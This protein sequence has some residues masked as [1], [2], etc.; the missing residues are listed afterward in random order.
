MIFILNTLDSLN[1]NRNQGG[2]RDIRSYMITCLYNA[3]ATMGQYYQQM[4]NHDNTNG[5]F[6]KN[7]KENDGYED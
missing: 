6:L 3:P 7:R 1:A 5:V 2:I 4:V